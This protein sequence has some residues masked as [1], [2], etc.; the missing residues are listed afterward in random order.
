MI[1]ER[2]FRR[3]PL[4]DLMTDAEKRV[5]DLVEHFNITWLSRVSDLNDLSRPLRKRSHYPTLHALQNALLK[6]VEMNDETR[7]HIDYLVQELNEV[8]Q[9]ARREQLNRKL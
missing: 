4:R 5:R 9:H 6:T 1:T 8:L 2:S 7:Q 3:L